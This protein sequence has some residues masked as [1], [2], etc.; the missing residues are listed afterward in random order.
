MDQGVAGLLGAAVGGAIGVIGTVSAA[1]LAGRGQRRS[2][3]E[4]WLRQVRRDAYAHFVACLHRVERVVG[5]TSNAALQ[6]RPV[7]DGWPEEMTQAGEALSA[8]MLEG[9]DEIYELAL[10]VFHLA[11]EW[12][13]AL[14]YE[15]GDP[16]PG[17][18]YHDYPSTDIG[19]ATEMFLQAASRVL[20]ASDQGLLSAPPRR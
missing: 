11:Q 9:P 13:Y 4:Q 3:H 6:G 8:V 17:D 15:H 5:E 18:T 7:P 19:A 12:W 20:R 2:Q 14:R 10:E 1:W 16:S